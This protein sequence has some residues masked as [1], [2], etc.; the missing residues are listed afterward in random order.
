MTNI[1]EKTIKEWFNTLPE[2]YRCEAFKNTSPDILEG[3]QPDL[4]TALSES[5]HWWDT[6]EG[7]EYWEQL[8]QRI[9][10]R[11]IH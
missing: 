9:L 6:N 2:P 3:T 11:S 5:F 4:P 7:G 8:H 1:A 10:N